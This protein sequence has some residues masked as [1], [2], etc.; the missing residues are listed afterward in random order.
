MLRRPIAIL[1]I[2]HVR[3]E[4]IGQHVIERPHVYVA[5]YVDPVAQDVMLGTL[6]Q[7]TVFSRIPVIS[8]VGSLVSSGLDPKSQD[9]AENNRISDSKQSSSF[10]T[11][12]LQCSNAVYF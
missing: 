7:L 12:L 6:F 3:L 10:L 9:T 5:F 8:G 4:L 2:L 11:I 1:Q